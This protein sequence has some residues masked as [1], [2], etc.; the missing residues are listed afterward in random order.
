MGRQRGR[1]VFGEYF[2]LGRHSDERLTSLQAYALS[3]A[4]LLLYVPLAK[5]SAVSFHATLATCGIFAAY[6]YRDVYPLIT[7]TLDPADAEEGW[8]VWTK[9]AFAGVAG[10]FVPM[11]EPHMYIPY[12]P[13]VST[14]VCFG[15]IQN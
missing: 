4:A 1:H 6:L 2:V 15:I 13:A 9:V 5:S 11:V 14:A 10:I 12:D 7:F 8:L 3:L